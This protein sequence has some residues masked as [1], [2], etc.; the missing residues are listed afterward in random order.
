ML[1]TKKKFSLSFPFLDLL[2]SP[3]IQLSASTL[4]LPLTEAKVHF[5][6]SLHSW[7][8][9][10]DLP[11]FVYFVHHFRLNGQRH[12]TVSSFQFS[13]SL[14]SLRTERTSYNTKSGLLQAQTN[15][16]KQNNSRQTLS[17]FRLV[18]P[19]AKDTRRH[20]IINQ[21]KY[22]ISNL[23]LRHLSFMFINCFV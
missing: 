1:E 2:D 19:L 20:Q 14:K 13:F 4:H 3:Y 7:Y 18:W 6:A 17:F 12:F 22:I 9:G 16:S 10:S 21:I 11:Q 23:V 15:Y 8:S 5:D